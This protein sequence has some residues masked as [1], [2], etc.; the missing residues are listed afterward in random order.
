[1][2]MYANNLKIC[3]S[4]QLYQIAVVKDGWGWLFTDEDEQFMEII[5]KHLDILCDAFSM[6]LVSDSDAVV[7][8]STWEIDDS[9]TF[10]GTA[11][12][13]SLYKR[14][15]EGC[16]T[17]QDNPVV[18]KADALLSKLWS[19]YHASFSFEENKDA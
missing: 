13:I 11:E 19:D 12:N 7:S 6:S 3:K 15:E 9:F 8:I 4:K 14:Y 16:P 10:E 2:L 5:N 17:A 18:K 1:M